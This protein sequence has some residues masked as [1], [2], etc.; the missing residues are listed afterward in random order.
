MA[1]FTCEKDYFVNNGVYTQNNLSL[2]CAERISKKNVT[3][4]KLPV[5]LYTCYMANEAFFQVGGTGTVSVCQACAEF[6][7]KHTVKQSLFD[8]AQFTPNIAKRL[9]YKYMLCSTLQTHAT[10][11]K[12]KSEQAQSQRISQTPSSSQVRIRENVIK[13]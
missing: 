1:Y 11:N 6:S 2:I 12:D 4:E 5:H 3:S 13:E 10:R 9:K 8:K 7:S